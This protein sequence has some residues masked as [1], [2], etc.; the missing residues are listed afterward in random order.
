MEKEIQSS[1]FKKDLE[2]GRRDFRRIVL[3]NNLKISGEEA[4]GVL[5]LSGSLLKA[6]HLSGVRLKDLDL[7][8]VDAITIVLEDVF[9]EDVLDLSNLQAYVLKVSGVKAGAIDVSG[10]FVDMMFSSYPVFAGAGSTKG[11]LEIGTLVI[12]KP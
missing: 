5:D 6:L 4:S 2:R 9:V 12:T 8:N 10:V 3:R 11:V 7:S 1:R